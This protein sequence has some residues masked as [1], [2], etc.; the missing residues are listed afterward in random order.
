MKLRTLTWA[1]ALTS[2]GTTAC[3]VG[4]DYVT[5]ELPMP[6]AWQQAAVDGLTTGESNIQTWWE[7]LQDPLFEE[8]IQRVAAGNLDLEIA[9]AR[10]HQARAVRGIATGERFPDVNGTGSATRQRLSEGQNPFIPP[11][12]GRTDNYYNLGLEAAWEIDLWG[13]VRNAVAAA[14]AEVE[15]SSA[16]F[17]SARLSLQAEVAR[18]WFVTR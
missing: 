16:D 4:P 1:V 15:A 18:I 8:L 13:R 3:K 5:P 14:G 9:F 7:Q 2:V 11:G 10:I 17:L 12:L 6:D